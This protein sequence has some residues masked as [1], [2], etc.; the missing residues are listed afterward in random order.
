MQDSNI[1]TARNKPNCEIKIK[2][3]V[4]GY[5]VNY[6]QKKSVPSDI[7]N[8]IVHFFYSKT[9]KKVYYEKVPYNIFKIR[10]YFQGLAKNDELYHKIVGC[11]A[12]NKYMIKEIYLSTNIRNKN[13]CVPCDSKLLVL[14]VAKE[15]GYDEQPTWSDINIHKDMKEI[16]EKFLTVCQLPKNSVNYSPLQHV[17]EHEEMDIDNSIKCNLDL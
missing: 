14:Q 13:E 17:I 4:A 10:L 7:I 12:S 1:K 2:L 16:L 5:C 15:I 11:L 6:Q 9:E 8:L 3:L